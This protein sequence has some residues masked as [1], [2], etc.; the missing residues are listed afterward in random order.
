MTPL[1]ASKHYITPLSQVWK[2]FLVAPRS[3]PLLV[4]ACFV[5][6]AIGGFRCL[7]HNSFLLLLVVDDTAELLRVQ[8]CTAN[9]RPIDVGLRHQLVHGFRGNASAV[10][11]RNNSI[12]CVWTGRVERKRECAEEGEKGG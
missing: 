1:R 2:N 6:L 7:Y 12:E 10:L 3:R 5:S 11:V 8:R 4:V 9:E